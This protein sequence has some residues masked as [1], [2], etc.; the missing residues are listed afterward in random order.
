M[1]KT[2]FWRNAANALPQPV[3]ARHLLLLERAEQ[4]ELALDAV[5]EGYK[6]FTRQLQSLLPHAN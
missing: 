6:G 1:L 5:V 2:T 3:R 4:W